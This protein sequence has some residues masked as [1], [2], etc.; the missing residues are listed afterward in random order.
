MKIRI[1]AETLMALAA[2]F[3]YV[4]IITLIVDGIATAYGWGE[5]LAFIVTLIVSLAGLGI[6]YS[7]KRYVE[8][9]WV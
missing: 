2:L 7:L 6:Y 5:P 3:L 4:A 8:I 1:R 9:E